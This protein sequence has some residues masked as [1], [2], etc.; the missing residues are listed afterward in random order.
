MGCPIIV[1]TPAQAGL[2]QEGGQE[3]P[4]G[5]TVDQEAASPVD[6]P[7]IYPFSSTP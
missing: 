2:I 5:Q 1:P 6:G 4:V 7:T 3:P